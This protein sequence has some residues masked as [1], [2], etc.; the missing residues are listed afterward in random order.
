MP[1]AHNSWITNNSSKSK[2][3]IYNRLRQSVQVKLW[4]MKKKWW[5]DQ[6][7]SIQRAADEHDMKRVY[8]SLKTMVGSQHKRFTPVSSSNVLCL[9]TNHNEIIQRWAE[10]FQ[11]VLN[12]SSVVDETVLEELPEWPLQDQL[13]ENPAMDE[14]NKAVIDQMSSGRAS[15]SDGLPSENF[16]FGGK[17]LIGK[18]L[19]L[20]TAV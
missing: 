10:H 14:V 11:S 19:Q 5:Q 1:K 4:I 9:L 7:H 2:R 8:I 13:I 15:G 3:L 6:A 12:R 18:L 17:H 20:Y 16:R